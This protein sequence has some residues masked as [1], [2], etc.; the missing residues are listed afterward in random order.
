LSGN[1]PF[2]EAVSHHEGTGIDVLIADSSKVTG[3]D[4]FSSKSYEAFIAK[5]R[6]LYDYI[7]IDTPPMLAVPDA[8]VIAQN[9]DAVVYLAHWDSTSRRMIRSGLD[10]LYQVN[11][12]VKG[13]ALTRM[14]SKR[15]HRYGY[16]GYGYQGGKIDKYYA[17]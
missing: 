12:H 11:V 8:R 9:T 13:L 15:M 7:I 17:N 5:M 3:V 1:T 10:L 16:F 4:V 14:D 6:D 2:E